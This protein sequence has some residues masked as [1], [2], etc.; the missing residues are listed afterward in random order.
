M[1]YY[2]ILP[3]LFLFM[4]VFDKSKAEKPILAF[5]ILFLLFFVGLRE[6]GTGTG[7]YYEYIRLYEKIKTFDDIFNANIHAEIGFRY[8]SYIGNKF[9]FDGQF[10]IFVM[11]ALSVIPVAFVIYKYSCYKILSL[12]IW[13]PFILT[14]NMQASRS[15]VAAAFGLVF[16]VSFFNKNHLKSVIFLALS[17]SFHTSAISLLAIYMTR[18]SLQKLLFAIFIILFSCLFLNPLILLADLFNMMGLGIVSNKILNYMSSTDY[19][20]PM[21]MYDPRILLNIFICFLIWHVKDKINDPLY[22][23]LCK[24]F[25]VGMFF[26]ILFASIT[27]ISLRVSFLYLITGVI[28]IPI[29]CQ[30]YNQGFYLQIKFKRVMSLFLSCAYVAYISV[31]AYMAEPYEFYLK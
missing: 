1:I 20:Y 26:M 2:L 3:F 30:I 27:V 9:G 14:M 6:G 31:L 5:L 17:L 22:I 25:C 13:Y 11:A 12:L 21:R 16:I 19:G 29:I 18:I 23:N 15:A 8:L 7:D 24:V 4:C 28:V 10:I